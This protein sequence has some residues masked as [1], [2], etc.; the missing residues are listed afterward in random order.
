[1]Q[2][3]GNDYVYV[4]C[5]RQPPPAD[6]V[7]LARRVSDRHFG[8]GSDGLILIL[9][10]ERAPVRMRMFN[11]DGSEGEMCG[12]GVRCLARYVH[13]SGYVRERVFGV[14][15]LAGVVE[16]EV[17]PPG[18]GPQRVR[19]D[20]GR[21][22]FRRADIPMSGPPEEEAR[23]L[24]LDVG[25]HVFRGTAVSVGNPHF[26]ILTQDVESVDVPLWGPRLERHPVFPQ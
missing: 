14:E 12:N 21:P 1:M 4:D 8:I 26:V 23:D 10:G 20:M 25:G 22:R 5:F 9:P 18:D 16:V 17:L 13:E 7:E 2:G 11:A 19:V 6:P 3:L 24:E 15:T